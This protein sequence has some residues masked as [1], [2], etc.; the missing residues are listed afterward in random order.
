M[1]IWIRTQDRNMIAIVESLVIYRQE[2]L[3]KD[4]V[5]YFED[6][7]RDEKD[8]ENT[9]WCISE[10]GYYSSKDKALKVLNKIQEHI[11]KPTYTND[12]VNEHAHYG[13]EVFQMP[14]DDEV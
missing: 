12:L 2:K 10:L 6:M 11:K 9:Y 7:Y 13:K 14:Q 5:E 4:G 8:N 1:G 3:T